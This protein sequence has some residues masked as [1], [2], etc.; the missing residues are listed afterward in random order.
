MDEK[1]AELTKYAANSFLATKITFMNEIAN[2]CEKVGADVDKV[3]AGMGTD[4]RIGKRFLFPGIGYGGS[5]FPKDVKALQK[6]GLDKD[7]DFKILNSVIEV[8][9]K[10]KTILIPKIENQFNHDL[11]NKKLAIWGLAFKP[12]TDDVR[13]A[14]AI[15]LMNELLSRGAKLS[16]YDPEA[17]PNIKKQFGDKL[18]YCESMYDALT[19]ADALVICT[20]WSIFRT[21]DFNKVKQLLKQNIIFDGRNLY[22]LEDIKKEGISYISIGR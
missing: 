12:E 3:R 19:D 14:P 2:Y 6:A 5:C 9:E 16:V 20:E 4:S 8:N 11:T 18:T 7:Y 22:D 17:M 10:Q 21:P 13:E 1:S 15:Y